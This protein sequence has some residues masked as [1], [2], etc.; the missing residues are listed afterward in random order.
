VSVVA[1]LRLHHRTGPIPAFNVPRRRATRREV[2][3]GR[4]P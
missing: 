3:P 4:C 1:D 2:T